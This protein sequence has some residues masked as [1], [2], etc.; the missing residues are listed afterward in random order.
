MAISPTWHAPG[1]AGFAVARCIPPAIRA[2]RGAG[3]AGSDPS[4]TDASA[5][6]VRSTVAGRGRRRHRC[7]FSA[8]RSISPRR[9]R[10]LHSASYCAKRLG[11]S[12]IATATARR[13]SSA[14]V[15]RSIPHPAHH[16]LIIR[17]RNT[18]MGS[19]LGGCE[20]RH[21]QPRPRRTFLHL[22]YSCAPPCGPAVL[23]T[24]D[25]ELTSE[26]DQ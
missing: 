9:A 15:G 13:N 1:D 22:S 7:A 19:H 26:L 18:G 3:P 14:G 2:S 20:E 6:A 23:V 4:T 5:S 8:A 10:V 17:R 16:V 12:A 11:A 25:P 21:R 24:Q